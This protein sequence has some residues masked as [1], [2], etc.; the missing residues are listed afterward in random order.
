MGLAVVAR[1]PR[2]CA[3]VAGPAG[4]RQD[5]TGRTVLPWRKE[6]VSGDAGRGVCWSQVFGRWPVGRL[7]CRVHR[8]SGRGV[9][10]GAYW[11]S[12]SFGPGGGGVLPLVCF[13]LLV[14]PLVRSCASGGHLSARSAL[15]RQL[16]GGVCGCQQRRAAPLAS[17]LGGR[18]RRRATRCATGPPRRR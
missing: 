18:W 7:F 1:E 13:V 5:R 15:Q 16:L 17:G 6:Q 9:V 12:S 3:T 2:E 14:S 8:Q 4:Q 10:D 11:P